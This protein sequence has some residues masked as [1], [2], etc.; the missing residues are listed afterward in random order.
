MYE[1]L[2]AQEFG[3]HRAQFSATKTLEQFDIE[4]RPQFNRALVR[5]L[6]TRRYQRMRGPGASLALAAPAKSHWVRALGRS[7]ASG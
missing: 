4:R 5:E 7:L 6:A 2:Q 3:S 1:S